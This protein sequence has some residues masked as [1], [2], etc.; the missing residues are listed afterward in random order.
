MKMSRQV[1]FFYDDASPHSNLSDSQPGNDRNRTGVDVVYQ[2][3]ILE[4]MVGRL[5]HI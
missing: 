4:A 2:P 1:E 3:T 5:H